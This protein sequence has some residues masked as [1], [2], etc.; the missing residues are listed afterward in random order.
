MKLFVDSSVFLKLLLDE[1]GADQA[2]TILEMIE[3]GKVIGYTTPLVLEEVS[4]KLI[5][6]KASEVLGTK[7]IWKIREALRVD[8]KTRVECGKVL[9]EFHKYVEHLTY[10]NLRVEPVT[11]S[12]WQNA[13]DITVKYGLLPADAIHVAVAL[14]L[15][16]KAIATFDEDFRGIK[17]IKIVP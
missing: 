15:G 9:K 7:N 4:F 5:Y 10:R 1:P 11:Y 13:A 8:G 12:D 6:A 17:E 3:E 16:A 14:R 2:Q